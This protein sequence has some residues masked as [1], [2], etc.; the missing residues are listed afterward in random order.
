MRL[1]ALM[2]CRS[3][4]WCVGLSAR[5]ALMWCDALVLL[6]HASDERTNEVIWRM[7]RSEL[8][9]RMMIAA[10]PDPA[11]HE[12]DHRQ[13]LLQHARA[14]GATHI[15]LVDADEVL[16][17]NLLDTVRRDV[18]ILPRGTVL[19]MP[20]YNLR[21]GIDR[22]HA[23]GLW[24]NRLFSLAFRDDPVL[25]WSGD[26]FHQREPAGMMLRGVQT[27]AQHAG[28]VL[29]LWG[30][31]ERRLRAKHALYKIT[32]RLRWPGKPVPEIDRMYS[33]WRDGRPECGDTP[34]RWVYCNV[35]TSWWEPYA[36]LMRYL[37]AGAAPWQEAECR[38]LIAEHG[39]EMFK[40]LDLF[41]VV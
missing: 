35:P 20:G 33:W 18:E 36:D 8:G 1:I 12:M 10:E 25:H 11:W 21:G 31:S 2:P 38:R 13:R 23:S 17:G 27:V 41:G 37:D 9:E 34:G 16:T 6:N 39:R 24:G 26:T 19:S 5:V 22:Y 3:D 30:A 4:A 29:H 32:E 14:F 15:A 40:G 28:G 7:L